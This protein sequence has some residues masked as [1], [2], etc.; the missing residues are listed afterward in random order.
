MAVSASVAFRSRATYGISKRVSGTN[1]L[2]AD[3]RLMRLVRK[4]PPQIYASRSVS[5]GMSAQ[6]ITQHDY[7]V[8]SR[9]ARTPKAK[10]K[11]CPTKA[12]KMK[13]IGPGTHP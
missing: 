1:L 6:G 2:T 8:S 4:Y 7:P 9:L 3:G 13:R 11:H 12:R 5:S 10:R